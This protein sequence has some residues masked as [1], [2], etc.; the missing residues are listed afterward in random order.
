M[1]LFLKITH[2][3]PVPVQRTTVNFKRSFVPVSIIE[4]TWMKVCHNN[5]SHNTYFITIHR[6][7]LST[8]FWDLF[9]LFVVL[10]WI[11]AQSGQTPR[12]KQPNSS[13]D[14]SPF[15]FIDTCR[16]YCSWFRQKLNLEGAIYPQIQG[17]IRGIY[18]GTGVYLSY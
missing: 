3:I 11:D 13:I 8:P 15:S 14:S 5:L 16:L 9:S 1:Y 17:S 18:D 4:S 6:S 2:V 12:R 10:S 7:T